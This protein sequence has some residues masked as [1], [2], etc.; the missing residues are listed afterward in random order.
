MSIKTQTRDYIPSDADV[1]R[2]SREAVA[3]AIAEHHRAG[4]SVPIWHDGRIVMLPPEQSAVAEE[5]AEYRR[6]PDMDNTLTH[7]DQKQ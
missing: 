5:E 2:A 3:A 7:G 4:R 1:E 6:T